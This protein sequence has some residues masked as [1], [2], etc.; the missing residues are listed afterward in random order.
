MAEHSDLPPRPAPPRAVGDLAGA[1][2]AWFG[3][4]RLIVTACC[5]LAVGAGAYWLVRSPVPSAE[6]VLPYASAPVTVTLPTPTPA[7]AAVDRVGIVVHVAGAVRSPGVYEFGPGDRVH[8]AVAAAG[9]AS[10]DALLE[11][12]NLASPLVDG[13]RIY[14]PSVGEVDPAT[15]PP[16]MSAA[17]DG[18]G[19]AGPLDL[20]R[21]TVDQFEALPG[22]GPA[23][24]AAIVEDR[25]RN[26][27]FASVDDL[28]RVPG[29]GPAKLAVLRDLVSV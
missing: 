17:G 7:P 21:A 19:P 26:G 25:T 28:D 20:N 15:I 11:G 14:V 24:A 10:G 27:P 8:D 9:G 13:A 1:W 22:V 16:G 5:T 4:G 23:T 12:L 3:L 29:I 18:E 6:A 2:L